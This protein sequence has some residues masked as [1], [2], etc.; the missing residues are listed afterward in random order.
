VQNSAQQN[1]I[2][3]SA[4]ASDAESK[5]S[6]GLRLSD[7]DDYIQ[8]SQECTKPVQQRQP[9]QQQQPKQADEKEK[10][11]LIELADTGEYVE[12]T[13]DGR[14]TELK[15]ASISLND[16]LACSGCIT[17]AESVLVT[18]QSASRFTALAADARA[19]G[20][21]IAVSISPESLASLAAAHGLTLV[22]AFRRLVALFVSFGVSLVADTAFARDIV[23]EACARELCA[24]YREAASAPDRLPMLASE[25]PG[26]VCY[27]EKTHAE[28]LPRLCR[29]KS[30][31]AL[32]GALI[33]RHLGRRDCVHA[34]V[35]PCFDKKLEA[36]REDLRGDVDTV[37][38]SSEVAELCPPGQSF[39]S[40]PEADDATMRRLCAFSNIDHDT[41]VLFWS[42]T[43]GMVS[44]IARVA[45]R[46]LLGEQG[47]PSIEIV[48]G[49]NIDF[50]EL[51]INGGK[52]KFATAYGFRNI[53]NIVRRIKQGGCPWQFVEV[54]A[55]PASC[56]NGGGQLKPPKG[57]DPKQWLE[58]V[59]RLLESRT[60]RSPE[61]NA[62]AMALLNDPAVWRDISLTTEYHAR[63]AKATTPM[64]IQW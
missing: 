20:A 10:R 48:R 35:A 45:A 14:R 24:R 43:N 12:V 5:F 36:A 42:G 31:M 60:V 25:C 18:A 4:M 37:L 62:A 64:Q 40:L 21:P 11:A 17:S 63:Q 51:L 52:L 38:A 49:R 8:P 57:T 46:E 41:G 1:N 29:C 59:R 9:A 22:A 15:A 44:H 55:C 39:A 3:A 2:D 61:Q 26:W 54:M 16:C 47:E 33:K 50:S 6:I 7:L 23:V 28:A 56:L 34:S 27:A 58:G 30:A 53:Q 13:A 32:T 19:R